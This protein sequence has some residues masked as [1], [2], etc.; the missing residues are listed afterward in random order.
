MR[1]FVFAVLLVLS[2]SVAGAAEAQR[3]EDDGLVVLRECVMGFDASPVNHRAMGATEE[4]L[5]ACLLEA[6]VALEAELRL[7][8]GMRPA[9]PPVEA[10]VE[11]AAGMVA[12]TS[13]V[14]LEGMV[15]ALAAAEVERLQKWGPAW[16]EQDPIARLRAV[17]G[18]LAAAREAL[19]QSL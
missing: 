10:G 12:T 17:V 3:A 16:L 4:G 9:T 2:P 18:S 11:G 6:R 8:D 5:Q 19:T 7:I 13:S 15:V 14:A 1:H